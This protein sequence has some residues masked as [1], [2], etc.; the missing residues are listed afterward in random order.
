MRDAPPDVFVYA[1]QLICDSARGRPRRRQVK[2]TCRARDHRD[3]LTIGQRRG[4]IDGQTLHA[5]ARRGRRDFFLRAIIGIY[6]CVSVEWIIWRHECVWR[7]TF[8][9]GH[10]RVV[11]LSLGFFFSALFSPTPVFKA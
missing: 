8:E 3:E 4:T 9:C 6:S 11:W 10:A 5:P 1:G 7:A 2:I